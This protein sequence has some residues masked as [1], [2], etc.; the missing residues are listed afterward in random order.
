MSRAR[1]CKHG[2]LGAIAR[3]SQTRAGLL[4]IITLLLNEGIPETRFAD[5]TLKPEVPSVGLNRV[6]R[7]ILNAPLA[8]FANIMLFC[9]SPTLERWLSG[10]KRQIANLLYGINR[11]EGS[12][13]SLSV[14]K[15]LIAL[16]WIEAR[17]IG[18][19]MNTETNSYLRTER[20]R[21]PASPSQR[22][23]CWRCPSFDFA[24]LSLRFKLTIFRYSTN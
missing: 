8:I 1:G 11:T 9:I 3:F 10:R 12:N 16:P 24:Q 23:D 19:L 15:T 5:S 6:S 2:A 4:Q 14:L 20:S 18:Y 22:P 13:P 17:A 7:L 21:S